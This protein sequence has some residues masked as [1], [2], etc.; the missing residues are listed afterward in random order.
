L[1]RHQALGSK[2]CLM[3]DLRNIAAAAMIAVL[4]TAVGCNAQPAPPQQQ[5][6]SQGSSN[7]EPRQ[8]NPRGNHLSHSHGV[9]EPPANGDRNVLPAPNEGSSA[10]PVIPPP[11]TPGGNQ[12][13]QPK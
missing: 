4:A 12:R 5:P 7:D 9:I 13:V 6:P 8:N 2:G 10:M 11:G 3:T 1:I